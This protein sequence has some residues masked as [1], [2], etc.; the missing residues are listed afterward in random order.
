MNWNDLRG[1][2]DQ[3][4]MLRRSIGRGRLAHAYLFAGPAGVGKSRF[5]RIFAQCLFCERH[6]DEELL[7]CGEC[8][9]CRQMQ[10]AS[11]PDFF[12]VGCPEGKGEIPVAVFY[13]SGEKRGKEGLIHDLSL[14]PMAG[15]RRVAI[16]DDANRMNDEGANGMLKTL[17]EPPPNSLLILIAENLDAV[18]PTIRS[19]C[20]LL[21]FGAL[22][23]DDV[24]D[25]L[26]ENELTTDSAEAASVAA[27]SDGSL[28]T[29][30]QLLNPALRNLR[31]RLY[32]FLSEP[33]MKPLDAAKALTSG[34]DEISGETHEQRRGAGW[35]IR[36]A[37]EFYRQ[38]VLQLSGEA[39]FSQA[40]P[41][42]VQQFAQR[43]RSR[44]LGGT[45]L[46][47]DLFDRC[48]LAENHIDW[49]I[50]PGK[51]IES[52]FDDLAR[53]SRSRLAQQA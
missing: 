37:Q 46:A 7:S 17:E 23:T 25:L 45:E 47:M 10:S 13:G 52:L 27:M 31:E 29:A 9:G 43:L 21:R 26:I 4:E 5:A 42:Q 28:Q 18:L 36:F 48:V 53:T 30:A 40:I 32:G 8:S 15:S 19:R 11:H 41:S 22:S 39:N 3:V 16:I 6:S 49:N 33:D 38:A 50:N 20:Q 14:R 2:G 44:G 24:A 1:H 12:L 35:L 51:A 34:L